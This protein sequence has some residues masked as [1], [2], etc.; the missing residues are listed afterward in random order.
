[1]SLWPEEV[2]FVCA[3]V[4]V[5]PRFLG[6]PISLC[7]EEVLGSLIYRFGRVETGNLTLILASDVCKLHATIRVS[8]QCTILSVLF[9][10]AGD[11][12]FVVRVMVMPEIE[13][14]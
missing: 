3:G 6:V 12:D 2:F 8:S 13:E 7:E 10:A 9:F 11:E 1:M 4:L 5:R 14:L